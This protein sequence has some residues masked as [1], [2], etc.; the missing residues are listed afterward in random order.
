MATCTFMEHTG[1]PSL[2]TEPSSMSEMW[3]RGGKD[4]VGEWEEPVDFSLDSGNGHLVQATAD[5]SGGQDVQ[6]LLEFGVF[7]G[8][9]GGCLRFGVSG[10][11][12]C[13]SSWD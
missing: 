7:G 9:A 6:D 2:P 1:I 11:V 10:Q 4:P 5:G 13:D 12:R 3:H 8:Q